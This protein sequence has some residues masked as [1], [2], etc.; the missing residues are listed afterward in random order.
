MKRLKSATDTI[1][2]LILA[3]LMLCMLFGTFAALSPLSFAEGGEQATSS[4]LGMN[5][6][7]FEGKTVSILSYSVSTYVGVSN[8][9]NDTPP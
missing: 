2:H 5:V 1:K 9:V 8:N 3:T 6:Y 4:Q 7:G